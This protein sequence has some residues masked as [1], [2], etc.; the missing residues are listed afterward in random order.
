MVVKNK[1][2]RLPN[3][4]GVMLKEGEITVKFHDP[5]KIRRVK[6]SRDAVVR[7][8]RRAIWTTSR[9]FSS[10]WIESELL[11]A[12]FGFFHRGSGTHA[13]KVLGVD[14]EQKFH[15][16]DMRTR[17]RDEKGRVRKMFFKFREYA[18]INRNA[19]FDE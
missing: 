6:S 14:G 18:T 4:S 8:Y 13:T 1:M 12:H 17:N 16:R 10:F 11:H 19:I 2:V 15:S 5:R 7:Q 3:V 9:K